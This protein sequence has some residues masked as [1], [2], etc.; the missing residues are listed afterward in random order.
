MARRPP[1]DRGEIRAQNDARTLILAE[2]LPRLLRLAHDPDAEAQSVLAAVRRRLGV[3][4]K[5]GSSRDSG[6]VRTTQSFVHQI[7]EAAVSEERQRRLRELGT[8]GTP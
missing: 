6:E 4:E 3:A 2:V 1:P 7:V 8:D 5:A